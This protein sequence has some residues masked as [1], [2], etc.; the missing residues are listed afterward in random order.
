MAAAAEPVVT[1]EYC[2][3]VEDVDVRIWQVQEKPKTTPNKALFAYLNDETGSIPVL[4]LG[5]A[6][7]AR[8]IISTD[9]HLGPSKF[10]SSNPDRR[11]MK[12]DIRPVE[13]AQQVLENLD[14][15]ILKQVSDHSKE[16][17]KKKRSTDALEDKYTRNVDVPPP[18]HPEWSTTTRAKV[19]IGVNT[20]TNIWVVD[21][22]NPD[23]ATRGTVQDLKRGCE[24][25]MKLQYNGPLITTTSIT[26]VPVIKDIMVFPRTQYRPGRF[27]MGSAR[28]NV[29]RD[30][31]MPAFEDG[32]SMVCGVT[33]AAAQAPSQAHVKPE[34]DMAMDEAPEGA[35]DTPPED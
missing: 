34:P 31:L 25:V 22:E 23:H 35:V 6:D 18:D 17:L 28:I 1:E 32:I 16:W 5:H 8:A 13:G 12:I 27:N 19:D 20:P 33:P 2:P 3:F 4:Q 9:W 24:A 7:G 10:E 15:F 11:L 14:D 26:C 29:H 21:P 30:Q